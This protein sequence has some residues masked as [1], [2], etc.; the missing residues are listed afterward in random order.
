M[1]Q[2]SPQVLN[3]KY[4]CFV[5][6]CPSCDESFTVFAEC[7]GNL[8]P[9]VY[10]NYCPICGYKFSWGFQKAA[11]KFHEGIQEDIKKRSREAM[12]VVGG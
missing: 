7:G 10:P 1:S 12:E 9:Y 2:I 11:E 5:V 3:L 8:D 4:E 6:R